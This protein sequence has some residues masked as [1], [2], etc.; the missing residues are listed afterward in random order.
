M[1]DTAP[2]HILLVGNARS[3]LERR[4]LGE[5]IDS[6]PVVVR[7]NNFVT[8]GFEDFVGTKT[9][10]WARNETPEVAPRDEP[11]AK[12]LLRLQGERESTYRAGSE[13]VLP[14]LQQEHPEVT[15][16]VIP[17]S[18][19]TELIET[20]Q[21]AHAPLTGT[22]VIAYLLRTYSR[23]HV[24]GFDNLSGTPETLRHYYSEGNII[25]DWTTY[26]EPDKEA[27]YLSSLIRQG[28]VVPL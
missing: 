2:R 24:C 23:V 14:R 6:F 4:G 13:T 8:A 3:L 5:T 15:I 18:V 25:G 9:D 17:R 27:A 19:F 1:T 22:L 16:E 28:R 21:F 11:F 26:H 10:W 12:I 20:Y 7:F